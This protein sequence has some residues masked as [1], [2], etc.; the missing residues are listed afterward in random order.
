MTRDS[1]SHFFVPEGLPR[2]VIFYAT[3]EF[4]GAFISMFTAQYAVSRNNHKAVL[5]KSFIES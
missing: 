3:S 1:F 4:A 5:C 2:P